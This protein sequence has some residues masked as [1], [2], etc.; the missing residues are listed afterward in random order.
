[1]PY[2]S[3]YGRNPEVLETT[4]DYPSTSLPLRRA[5]PTYI[6][7]PAAASRVFG[8]PGLRMSDG[9]DNVVA[10]DPSSVYEY[11][12]RWK[13]LGGVGGPGDEV[14]T[15][16]RPWKDRHPLQY[17]FMDNAV[18]LAK[19]QPWLTL[20]MMVMG[21]TIILRMAGVFGKVATS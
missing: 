8:N 21:T 12:Q 4:F 16:D 6:K 14:K 17:S 1:M 10:L 5:G 19:E 18:G 3:L 13:G 11:T 20:A 9:D 2:V 15:D 7:L